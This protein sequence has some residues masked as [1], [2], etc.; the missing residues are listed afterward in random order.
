MACSARFAIFLCLL[1][2]LP[3][4]STQFTYNRLDWLISWYMDD[5]I[6]LDREQKVMFQQR[7]E[8]LLEW[9]RHEELLG[10]VQFL[11]GIENDLES[12]LSAETVSLWVDDITAAVERVESRILLLMIDIGSGM[13]D[14]QV[15]DFQEKLWKSQEKYN[16][17][18]LA[19]DD[20]EYRKENRES[21][22]KNLR[23][24]MGRL[25]DSQKETLAKAMEDIQR[26]DVIWLDDRQQWLHKLES[27]LQREPGWQQA[28]LLAH[29]EREKLRSQQY[30]DLFSHNSA[31]IN[32][33][34]AT[35]FNQR[36]AAQD[37]RLARELARLK[38]DF[39][40][41]AS[42]QQKTN[43]GQGSNLKRQPGWRYR[44]TRPGDE[45]IR[46]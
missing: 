8:P 17:K 19:R 38:E 13:S 37:A 23:R 15:D 35:V 21:L 20:A 18:Y 39:A 9:H 43:L 45:I 31:V 36:N 28:I 30:R 10:Y 14:E 1:V 16:K 46:F 11:E 40:E 3:G 29:S 6:D 33:A 25:N 7:L 26:F 4:C 12:E 22:E 42:Q 5:Y 44:A 24:F 2:M 41:L 34:I 27:L 32:R